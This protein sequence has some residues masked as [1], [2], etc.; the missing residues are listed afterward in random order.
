MQQQAEFIE[1]FREVPAFRT[2]LQGWNGKAWV[3]QIERD[4]AKQLE[5][6]AISLSERASKEFG[7][8]KAG[9]EL[10]GERAKHML[11]QMRNLGIG[12]TAPEIVG[13]DQDGAEMRL[14]DFRGKVV[15]LVFWGG[16]CGPCM[17]A[18]PHER[19]LVNRMKGKP[20]VMLGVN[21]DEPGKL[22]E[23]VREKRINWRSWADGSIDGPRPISRAWNV[24]P[25]PK[26]YV[27]DAGGVI[28]CNQLGYGED[29]ELDRAVEGLIGG[30]SGR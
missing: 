10:I 15:A 14:S 29:G 30:V 20:F 19:E 21:T 11:F 25:W 2:K 16:W 17:A 9:D 13:K 18:V 5:G 7:D 26:V 24:N 22:K 12:K 1:R 23:I 3:E 4:D 6:R 27:I 8:V 28:R